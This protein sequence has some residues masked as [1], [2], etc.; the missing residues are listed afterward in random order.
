MRAYDLVSME[1]AKA[2][3]IFDKVTYCNDAYDTLVDAGALL[4]ATEW[5]E[6]RIPNWDAVSKLLKNKVVFGGR[7]IYKKKSL[8]RLALFTMGLRPSKTEIS[9]FISWVQLSQIRKLGFNL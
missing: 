4:L 3:Y 1:E 8:E 7:N 2:H 5:S 9:A 6:F